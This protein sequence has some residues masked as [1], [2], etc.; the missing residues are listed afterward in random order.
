MRWDVV[1]LNAGD[2][3]AWVLV[4][5][6]PGSSGVVGAGDTSRATN[7]ANVLPNPL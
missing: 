2:V 3:L 4:A 6:V 7:P 5:A 1:D